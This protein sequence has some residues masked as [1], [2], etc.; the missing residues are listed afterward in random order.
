MSIISPTGVIN[1]DSYF[2]NDFMEREYASLWPQTWLLAANL[3]DLAEDGDFFVFEFDRESFLI[4]RTKGGKIRA[5]YNVCPHRGDRLVYD[6]SGSRRRFMRRYHSWSFNNTGSVARITDR[7]T[8]NENILCGVDGLKEVRCETFGLF[9]FINMG[10]KAPPLVEQLGPVADFLEPYNIGQMRLSKDVSCDIEANWKILVDV[11]TELYHIHMAHPEAMEISD[12]KGEIELFPNGCGRVHIKL[13]QSSERIPERRKLGVGKR[14]I[15]EQYGGD[16]TKLEDCELEVDEVRLEVAELKRKWTK[17]LGFEFLEL[18]QEQ[19]VDDHLLLPFLNVMLN[20]QPEALLFE[21]WVPHVDDP[22]KS[23]FDVQ[24]Y[25]IPTRDKALRD[26][27]DG[28]QAPEDLH[29]GP[30]W[31]QARPLH[32]NLDGTQEL[33]FI[34]NQDFSAIPQVQK[35]VRSK[36]FPA[37]DFLGRKLCRDIIKKKSPVI[38]IVYEL[39]N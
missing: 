7:E 27:A 26:P 30:A 16:P 19:F 37:S 36:D 34:L 21:R 11:F 29:D 14:A 20:I 5:F 6:E 38:L 3:Q 8:F 31:F 1:P 4:T 33:G 9:V 17:K 18:S 22:Q 12:D 39:L 13:A 28:F 25:F 10:K 15:L 23:R 24:V 2:S 35:G 32:R